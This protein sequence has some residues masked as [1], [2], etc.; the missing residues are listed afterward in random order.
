MDELV[1]A[2]DIAKRLGLSRGQVVHVWRE[3]YDTF[4]QPVVVRPRVML[5]HWPDVAAWVK[6]TGRA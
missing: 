5:W 6:Q 2:A 1:T 4:P 3:R